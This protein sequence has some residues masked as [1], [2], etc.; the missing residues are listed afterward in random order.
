MGDPNT[1][2]GPFGD[3]AELREQPDGSYD[4]FDSKG[5][6]L[7]S[8]DAE[9]C[10]QVV[11]MAGIPIKAI[12][13]KDGR[14]V[15][16]DKSRFQKDGTIA[17]DLE[18]VSLDTGKTYQEPVR[19]LMDKPVFTKKGTAPL[20][21]EGHYLKVGDRV[22]LTRQPDPSQNGIYTVGQQDYRGGT[23]VMVDT[24]AEGATVLVMEGI[25]ASTLWVLTGH[26]DGWQA[27]QVSAASLSDT[28]E[29][30][31]NHPDDLDDLIDLLMEP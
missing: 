29:P 13:H 21:V 28:A 5:G 12:V 7:L 1:D 10:R 4:A 15:G 17:F 26:Y 23:W 25:H 9:G 20:E 3:I 24:P 2:L 19:F 14:R 6:Y 27:I 16:F 11:S 31:P 18:T 22:L 8:L 30:P